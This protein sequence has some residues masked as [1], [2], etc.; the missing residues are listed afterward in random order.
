[1]LAVTTIATPA[2]DWHAFAPDLVLVATMVVVLVTD[3]L[4]P[5]REAWRTS[6]ITALGLLAA[7]I[8]IATLVYSGHD[9]SM[10]DGAYVVDHYALALKAF[11]IVTAYITVLISVDYIREG[12]YY[13]GEYYFL[14]LVSTFGMSIMASARDLI[15]LFVALETISI[16]TFVLAAFRKHDRSSNEAGVKYYLIGVL[17]SAIML[18]GFSIIYGVTGATKL[19]DIAAY[20]SQNGVVP[21]VAVAIFLSL[22]GFAFKVSAVPFHFWAP[23]TY[24]GAPTPVTAFLS[25]ASKAGGFVALINIVY[26]GFFLPNGAAAGS[27][28]PVLWVLAAASMTIGNLAALRQTNIVRMLAY[29]S[30][31]QGGFMLVPFAAAGIAGADGHPEKAAGAMAAVVVYLLIYGAMN[32]GAFAV[33][34]AVARR[35]RSAEISTY[36]GLFQT[37]PTM[38]VIMGVFLA[39]L[40]GIPFFAGWFAKFVMFRSIIDAGTGWAIALA[41]IAA[42]NSVIAFFYYARPIRAMIFHEPDT[43]DRSPLVVPQPLMVAIALTTAVVVVVGVYPQ[44]FARVGELAF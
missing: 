34:I 42:V 27:W 39:S 37:A 15:T 3:L 29:S 11:F 10:F 16:P 7:L 40:A 13:N 38:A 31:A 33:V 17:S 28:W 43:D 2:F 35:T 41:V 6:S 32:L 24:E 44:L 36:D 12:D 8:P 19:S 9:R 1:V 25:V 21:L 23:D 26:F 18:Y 30:I 20:M 5:D 4:L 14:L 22:V